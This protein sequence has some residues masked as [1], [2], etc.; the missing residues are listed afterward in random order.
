MTDRLRNTV[1]IG[2]NAVIFYFY[3]TEVASY[4]LNKEGVD[5]LSVNFIYVPALFGLTTIIGLKGTIMAKALWFCFMSAVP[6]L[7][8]GQEGEPAK[9]GLQWVLIIGMQLPYWVAG[10]FIGSIMAYVNRKT[11]PNKRV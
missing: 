9:P 3:Y 1:W 2:L 6:C 7:V 5:P 10:A 11:A 8:L 4:W